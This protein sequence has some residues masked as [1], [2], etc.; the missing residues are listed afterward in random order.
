MKSLDEIV[1][2]RKAV[3]IKAM[4]KTIIN[5]IHA[6]IAANRTTISK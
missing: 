5:K 4:Q 2:V 1:L 6:V 3:L